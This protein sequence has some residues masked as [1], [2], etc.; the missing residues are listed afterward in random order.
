MVDGLAGRGRFDEVR[1]MADRLLPTR[2]ALGQL[3][4]APRVLLRRARRE[5]KVGGGPPPSRA[6]S[7]KVPVPPPS[8]SL[9]PSHFSRSFPS[10]FPPLPSLVTLSSPS[11]PLPLPSQVAELD[12]RAGSPPFARP[13][14]F[15]RGSRG[16][17]CSRSRS[18]PL[19]EAYAR[20]LGSGWCR[21][22]RVSRVALCER[23]RT[24]LAGLVW[25]GGKDAVE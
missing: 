24:N 6:L 19:Q 21:Q 3:D 11:T 14:R 8:P 23:T 2:A 9:P 22:P 5:C 7:A 12:A 16:R 10:L 1:D 4:R 20:H 18:T 17:S 15:Y 13:R 25:E